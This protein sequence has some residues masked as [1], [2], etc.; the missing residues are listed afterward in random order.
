[1][2]N[3]G[4]ILATAAIFAAESASAS[5]L[6][7]EACGVDAGRVFVETSW[8]ERYKD[9]R[10][11]RIPPIQ[12][13]A[14][15]MALRRSAKDEEARSFSEFWA[16]WSLWKLG[17]H[18]S[19]YQ[20]L[21]VVASREVVPATRGSQEAALN[22]LAEI[23]AR[24]PSFEFPRALADRLKDYPAGEP[25]SKAAAIAAFEAA[26]AGGSE[27]GRFAELTQDGTPY[28]HFARAVASASTQKHEET[29]SAA[30][31]YFAAGGTPY[32]RPLEDALRVLAGRALYSKGRYPEASLQFQAVQKSSNHFARSLSDLA[33]A[34]LRDEKYKEALGTVISLHSGGFRRTF[35]PEAPMVM[36]MAFN[37]ICHYPDSLKAVEAFRLNYRTSF[38][39]LKGWNAAPASSDLYRLAVAFLKKPK[40]SQVPE[41]VASE[42]V[43]SP[44]FIGRQ[45]EL[46]LLLDTKK[47][48]VGLSEEGARLQAKIAAELFDHIVNLKPR[49]EAAKA[50]DPEGPLPLRVQQDVDKLRQMATHYR[51]MKRA[52][53]AWRLVLDSQEKRAVGTEKRLVAGVREDL[54]RLNR[55]M[56]GQLEDVADN[57]Y[58]VEVEIFQ[59]AT[60]DIIWQ[61]AHP[62][63]K[64]MAEQLSRE[65]RREASKVW[66]WGKITGG[67]AGVQEIWEDELGS[68]R[69]DLPDNCESKEKYLNIRR[70]LV[71]R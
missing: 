1:M 45:D 25:R 16:S 14:E 62:E 37:E 15:A 49:F 26:G 5:E 11:G 22:C 55:R 30:A 29:W 60:Q 42:W 27:V 47:R 32:L 17:L 69:A 50:K 10:Y 46:N 4:I 36:A 59:G 6:S 39:W 13:F 12:S 68:F 23:H 61:N 64:K 51:R 24:Y 38:D 28:R 57:I 70:T 2:R 66:D 43:R 3:F 18:H 54:A 48:A 34:W 53:P 8:Q 41:R 40:E 21:R 19:A 58:F 52:A 44:A 71:K 56:L 7:L 20:A 63:F 9:A 65:D 33:W 35:A 67:L 31:D